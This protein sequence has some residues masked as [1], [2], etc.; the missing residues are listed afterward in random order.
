MMIAAWGGGGTGENIGGGAGEDVTT[1][2][3][4]GR[5]GEKPGR[6][7]DGEGKLRVVVGLGLWVLLSLGVR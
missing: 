1:T 4:D 5:W 3:G 7:A 6:A 2:D